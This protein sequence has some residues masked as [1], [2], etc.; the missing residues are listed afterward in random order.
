MIDDFRIALDKLTFKQKIHDQAVA[1][2]EKTVR[3]LRK[4]IALIKN[5]EM[6]IDEDQFD[7]DQQAQGEAA[8]EVIH[9]LAGQLHFELEELQRLQRM[10]IKLPLLEAAAPGA[11]VVT[12]RRTFYICVGIEDFEVENR[13]IFGLS[14]MAPIYEV[15]EGKK[16]GETFS[17]R[18]LDYLI[19][20]VF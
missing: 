8:H 5:G 20:D 9:E 14:P 17:F 13:E 18:N 2:V 1:S 16:K 3:D 6:I 4:E 19:E 10:D 11:V 12:N 15:M 7:M